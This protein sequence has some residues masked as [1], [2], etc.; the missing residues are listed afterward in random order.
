MAAYY[1]RRRGDRR[2]SRGKYAGPER[3][4]GR[5]RRNSQERR[6]HDRRRSNGGEEDYE[7]Y[8]YAG[9]KKKQNPMV[10]FGIAGGAVLLIII[11]AVAASGSSRQRPDR[12]VSENTYVLDM[13]KRAQQLVLQG[14]SAMN[15]ARRANKE[16]GQS[17]ADPYYREAYDYFDSAHRLYEELD[18]KYPSSR[19]TGA[20]RDVEAALSE[21]TKM[22]GT[23]GRR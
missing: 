17:A 6:G 7:G 20:L 9:A 12:R 16:S 23:G 15:A 10:F 21:V 2:G 13:E 4:A 11:I 5:D 19:F 18:T 1:D 22:M 3:R 8:Y 14:G